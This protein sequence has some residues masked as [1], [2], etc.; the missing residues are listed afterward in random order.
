M[1][2]EDTHPNPYPSPD[3][4]DPKIP[5][6]P[7]YF[8]RY[9]NNWRAGVRQFQA[10]LESG[11][12]DPEWLRQAEEASAQRA[13]GK[14]D[15][16][17]EREYEEFWGQKQNFDKSLA[18]GQ[19]SQ[20]KLRTLIDQGLVREGD[21]W[22]YSRFIGLGANKILIEKEVKVWSTSMIASVW[23]ILNACIDT[24]NRWPT[25]DICYSPW[26]TCVSLQ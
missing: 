3:D 7:E 19:S 17:K 26:S 15:K 16:F 14:F 24:I 6:L 12:Y 9:S 23:A 18:A 8:L 25:N 1:L 11:R 5:P 2:P 13:A 22:K 20:V 4:P 21:V 10:D